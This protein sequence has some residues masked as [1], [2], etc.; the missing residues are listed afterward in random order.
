MHLVPDR[1]RWRAPAN[2]AKKLGVLQK[3]GKP[4]PTERLSAL[5]KD[6]GP[7]NELVS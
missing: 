7:L 6:S 2:A 5:K 3:A 1:D 4:Q